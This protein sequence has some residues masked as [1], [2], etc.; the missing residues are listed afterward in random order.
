MFD[1]IE[2]ISLNYLLRF[3]VDE[4]FLDSDLILVPFYG[5]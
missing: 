3:V 1:F 5:L 4:Q 2:T